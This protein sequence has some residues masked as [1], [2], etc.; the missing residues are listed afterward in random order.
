MIGNF[1]KLSILVIKFLQLSLTWKE[2]VRL[3]I[4]YRGKSFQVICGKILFQSIEVK[5][6]FIKYSTSSMPLESTDLRIPT[7]VLLSLAFLAFLDLQL[8]IR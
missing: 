1:L 7:V 3:D 8:I 2:L 4:E 5:S 6:V